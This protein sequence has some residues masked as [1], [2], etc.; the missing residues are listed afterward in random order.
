[1]MHLIVV[2]PPRKKRAVS[3][4]S[5]TIKVVVG[6]FGSHV[7]SCDESENDKGQ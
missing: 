3:R 7:E 1:M 6:R 2:F 4:D 5:L